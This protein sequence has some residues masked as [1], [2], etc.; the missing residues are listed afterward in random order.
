MLPFAL[1]LYIVLS[2]IVAS[3]GVGRRAGFWGA[4]LLSLA[5][6]PFLAFLLMLAFRSREDGP[7][8]RAP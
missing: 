6:T 1:F 5:F 4:L 2:L 8:S 3:F 7:A